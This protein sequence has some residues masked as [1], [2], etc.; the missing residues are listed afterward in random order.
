MTERDYVLGT[1]DQEIVRLGVQHRVWR[2]HVL[3]AWRR[4]GI[5][6]GSQ[7]LDVGAGP[8][9]ATLDLAG[10]VGPAGRV[11]AV[12]RSGRFVRHGEEACRER[13]L[14]QVRWHEQDVMLEPVSERGFDAA[15]CR[16]VAAFVDRPERLVAMLAECVRKGGK[17]VFHEYADYRAWRLA[18]RRPAF[19][20]FVE[21]VIETWRATGGEPD[22]ALDL[23]VLLD[24]AGF[25]VREL[26]P[27]VF[28]STPGDAVWSWPEQFIDSGLDRLIELGRRDTHRERSAGDPA[29]A[30]SVRAEF[31]EA[32]ADPRT[33]MLTPLVLEIIAE[34]L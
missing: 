16:W 24:Q 30:E 9:Y 8:G 32:E 10:I 33:V 13:G 20:S 23:P 29:W 22:I 21:R 27:I 19:E 14:G 26:K 15:W 31:R 25:R 2:P 3:D 4:A 5:T 12:E 18:P 28:A 6:A 34:R 17:A 11:V 1:H 7:V